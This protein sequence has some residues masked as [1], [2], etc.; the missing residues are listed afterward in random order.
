MSSRESAAGYLP[1][2]AEAVELWR[3]QPV[4]LGEEGRNRFQKVSNLTA[5]AFAR[6]RSEELI[7]FSQDRFAS[8]RHRG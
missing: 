8:G 1:L 4:G 5:A 2:C 6:W 7:T 3:S